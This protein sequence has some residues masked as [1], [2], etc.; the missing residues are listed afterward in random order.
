MSI[1]ETIENILGKS[2]D[3]KILEDLSKVFAARLEIPILIALV[4][5][6]VLF[7]IFFIKGVRQD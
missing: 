5:F 4:V 6:G 3:I 2:F 1:V 7:L